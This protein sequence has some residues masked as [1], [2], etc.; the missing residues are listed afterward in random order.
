MTLDPKFLDILKADGVKTFGLTIAFGL[1]FYGIHINVIPT[2]DKGWMILLAVLWLIV[3]CLALMSLISASIKFLAPVERIS[4]SFSRWKI[5]NEAKSYLPFMTDRER[6]IIS[7]LLERNWQTFTC[8]QDGG[9]AATL[10]STRIVI[11]K[12][13]PGQ[14]IHPDDVPFCIPPDIWKMLQRHRN[15][16]PPYVDDNDGAYPWRISWMVRS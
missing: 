13:Q 10:I 2:P 4:R 6:S 7:Y 8:T 9:Y 11:M 15:L 16:F 12:Y 3:G 14:M 1:A 5:V